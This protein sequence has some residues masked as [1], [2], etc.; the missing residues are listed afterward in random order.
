MKGGSMNIPADGK[1][2]KSK[3]KNKGWSQAEDDL[4]DRRHGIKEGSAAD[5][6]QDRAHGIK[7]KKKKKSSPIK[8]TGKFGGKSNALGQGGR[9]AQMRARGVPGGVIG[10]IARREHAAPG[11]VNYHKKKTLS[12]KNL[13][14]KKK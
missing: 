7:D 13:K 10:A 12:K 9:A 3:L 4:Y 11:Q 6:K 14:A 5:I 2:M 1:T 8:H